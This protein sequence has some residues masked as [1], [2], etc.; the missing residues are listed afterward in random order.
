M[1][2]E[3][4]WVVS[5]ISNP[6]RFRSR[7]AL[8]RDFAERVRKAGANLLTVELALGGRHFEVTNCGHERH[9]QLRGRDEIWHKENLINLGVQC[10][11]DSWEYVAWLDADI[12]FVRPDWVS[13]IVHQLQHYK[14]LQVFRDAIDLGPEG[15]YLQKHNGFA[16]SYVTGQPKGGK[17]YGYPHWHPGFGWACDRETFDDLGGLFDVGILGSGDHHMAWALAGHVLENAPSFISAGYKRSLKVWQDRASARVRQD[18]GFMPGTI[19]HH[20]HGKKADRR[21]G[22]RW[23]I[24]QKHGYD[25]DFDIQ[26]DWQGVYQLSEKGLRMRNDIRSYFRARNEDSIDLE[27]C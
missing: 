3:N 25:P 7:Y 13:E 2:T 19:L 22:D 16:W 27:C 21:Y 23:A 26:R 10:L 14:V 5:V 24:L 11:P 8:Y 12:E 4:L 15:Q 6:V 17:G 9:I 20:W 18:F 1:K